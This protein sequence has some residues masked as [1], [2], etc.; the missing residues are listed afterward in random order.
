MPK[1]LYL[2]TEDWFFCSHFLERAAA[3]QAA[4][5]DVIVVA[6]EGAHGA[7]IRDA[8][9][10]LIPLQMQ[11]RGLNPLSEWR[12][13]LAIWRIYREERPDLLHHIALKPILYGS[14][15]ARL[16]GL[17]HFINAPVG[18]G[19]VFTSSGRL[20]RLLR[21]LVLTAMRWLLNPAGSKV[22]FE[23]NDDLRDF[24]A[25]DMVRYSDA[26]LIRGAGVNLD[27][28]QQRPEPEGVPVV[29]LTARMLW[30]KGVGEFVEA[31]RQLRA[32]GLHARFLLLGAPDSGNPA[33]IATEQLQAWDAEGVVEW[34]GYQDDIPMA[35]ASSHVVCLPS[36]REGLPKSLIEALAAGRPIV[37][38][39]VPG[40]REVVIDGENGLLVPPRDATALGKALKCLILDRRLRMRLGM[41]GRQ[42]AERE[43]ASSIVIDATQ[44]LYREMLS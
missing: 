10:R 8:G 26:V 12:T 38:T 35:L 6:R 16:A 13:L 17:R 24:V 44:H 11:R 36:Y 14:L 30:D 42:R 2:I 7:V 28:F 9:L 39:D 43:F 15:C 34:L 20:A 23:N 21:P 29:V 27:L 1:L 41:K 37:T 22:V 40:C 4:G 33:A 5:Y 32:E 19:F 25:K 31:A 18:M 3:A